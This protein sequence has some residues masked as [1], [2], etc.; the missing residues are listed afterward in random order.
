MSGAAE[1]LGTAHFEVADRD[2]VH[3]WIGA[4]RN[5]EGKPTDGI[6]K[7]LSCAHYLLSDSRAART[8]RT[9]CSLRV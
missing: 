8:R 9:Q 6:V 5:A 2:D 3:L 4:T 1:H 7:T